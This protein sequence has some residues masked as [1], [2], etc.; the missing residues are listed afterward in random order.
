[1]IVDYCY[2]SFGVVRLVLVH[3]V[4]R[5]RVIAFCLILALL[6][7]HFVLRLFLLS[8]VVVFHVLAIFLVLVGVFY[9]FL[10]IFLVFISIRQA[11]EK[12]GEGGEEVE[13]LFQG[14]FKLHASQPFTPLAGAV[15]CGNSVIV[16]AVFEAYGHPGLAQ[17]EVGF[18]PISEFSLA[19]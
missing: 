11:A 13:G 7:I 5:I 17:E 3:I 8:I 9:L 14:E 12:V 4:V 19:E 16:N 15:F 1:M 2:Y 18:D 10:L 6:V